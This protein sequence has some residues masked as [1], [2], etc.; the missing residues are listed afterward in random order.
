MKYFVN[1]Y[2]NCNSTTKV[3]GICA[4]K[5]ECRIFFV[6]YKITYKYCGGLYVGN[7]QNKLKIMEQHFQYVAKK[8]IHDNNSYSF[9]AHYVRH[10]KRKPIPQEYC[11]IMSFGIISTVN[12]IG[13]MK[14][15]GGLSC[16][17]CK[18]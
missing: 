2:C 16:S 5:S 18:K 15:W 1:R 17:I 10:F 8:L 12:F 6:I 9:A 13:S 11:D 3:N 4:Y 14:S 7:T